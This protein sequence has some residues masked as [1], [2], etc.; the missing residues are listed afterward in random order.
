MQEQ[1]P[2][3]QAKILEEDTAVTAKVK[4]I[5]HEWKNNRPKEAST[6]P[7]DASPAIKRACD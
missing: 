2:A 4:K 1:T 3:L 6:R 7:E 5:E